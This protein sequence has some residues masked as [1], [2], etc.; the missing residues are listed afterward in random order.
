MSFNNE[1]PD[2]ANGRG[3]KQGTNL[4]SLLASNDTP[5]PQNVKPTPRRFWKG[6]RGT[7]GMAPEST[8]QTGSQNSSA[9][10]KRDL[11]NWPG[12]EPVVRLLRAADFRNITG[13]SLEAAK[14]AGLVARAERVAGDMFVR[15]AKG[16]LNE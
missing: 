2:R 11:F 15:P 10:T 9:P 14:E 6:W 12:R 1:A 7:A 13:L 5:K 16:V 8:K 3:A 4:G